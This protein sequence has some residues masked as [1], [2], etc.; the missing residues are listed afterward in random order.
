MNI[1]NA[2][3]PSLPFRAKLRGK[4]KSFDGG[5]L[6]PQGED[7]FSLIKNFGIKPTD[8]VLDIGCASG[9]MARPLLKFLSQGSYRGFDIVAKGIECANQ[10]FGLHF[11]HI[12]AYNM[13]YNPFG[14]VKDSE[15]TFPYAESKFS[16]VFANSIFT[17]MLP[18]GVDRY[19]TELKRVC[20]P[21]FRSYLTFLLLTEES[22]R[23]MGQNK[24][25]HRLPHIWDGYRTLR[26]HIGR[27]GV[28]AYEE[29][30]ISQMIAKAGLRVDRIVYGSW[31]G[32][33][34]AT[35]PKLFQDVIAVTKP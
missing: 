6:D 17:H 11:D 20:K 26:K 3:Y 12:D 2:L 35:M 13:L 28:V 14:K 15:V 24:T 25:A 18:E 5:D 21:G 30:F 32:V 27:E 29:K 4:P 7:T 34:N 1:L 16:F 8:D 23:R 19:F 9:R 31:S 33:Q 22:L 10:E